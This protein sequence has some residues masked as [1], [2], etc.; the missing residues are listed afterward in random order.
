MDFYF[1]G[2]FQYGRVGRGAGIWAQS[3]IFAYP[4]QRSGYRPT[5]QISRGVCLFVCFVSAFQFCP[6]LPVIPFRLQARDLPERVGFFFFRLALQISL[7][8][9]RHLSPF[10][11]F[12]TS[13]LPKPL[14]IMI[15]IM[16]S[17]CSITAAVPIP[18]VGLWLQIPS[19][20]SSFSSRVSNQTFGHPFYPFYFWLSFVAST[21]TFF[22]LF[23]IGPQ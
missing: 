12:S 22:F 5:G 11:S 3:L 9:G 21:V 13:T 17:S 14:I 2:D 8:W 7:F 6:V 15:L 10:V 20:P 16:I 19:V 4:F 18:D 1:D 23:G